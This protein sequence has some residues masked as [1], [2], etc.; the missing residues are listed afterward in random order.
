[1]KWISLKDK[2]P[3]MKKTAEYFGDEPRED[4]MSLASVLTYSKDYGIHQ[5]FCKKTIW[6]SSE[7]GD[8][9]EW[10]AQGYPTHWMPLPEL[11]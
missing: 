1:M 4:F 9:V 8:K 2:L 11:P 10:N 6:K 7:H 5:N 3:P